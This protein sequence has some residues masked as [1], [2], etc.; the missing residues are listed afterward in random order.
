VCNAHVNKLVFLFSC[1]SVFGQYRERVLPPLE[2]PTERRSLW[3]FVTGIDK[4]E[5]PTLLVGLKKADRKGCA[6]PVNKRTIKVKWE[7]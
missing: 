2:C 5:P 6:S 3:E 7:S 1:E 4:R